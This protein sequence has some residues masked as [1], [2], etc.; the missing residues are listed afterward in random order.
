MLELGLVQGAPRGPLVDV[1]VLVQQTGVWYGL[2]VPT[3][4]EE[5][6]H[7]SLYQFELKINTQYLINYSSL[8][9]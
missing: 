3:V 8:Q 5:H 4:Y 7:G 6:I 9:R 2:G 1:E